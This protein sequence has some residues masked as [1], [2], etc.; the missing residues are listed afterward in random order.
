M[1][2]RRRKAWPL[3]PAADFDDTVH[4]GAFGMTGLY[5][6]HFRIDVRKQM[7]GIVITQLFPYRHLPLHTQFR[8]LA[9]AAIVD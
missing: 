8:I 6:T 3:S 9:N 5:N 7:F 2:R 1:H 4:T